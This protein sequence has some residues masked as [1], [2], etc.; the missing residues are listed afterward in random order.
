MSKPSEIL[1]LL[2]LLPND[3]IL[4]YYGIIMVRPRCTLCNVHIRRK[5]IGVRDGQLYR[6]GHNWI[7]S[8]GLRVRFSSDSLICL[9][10]HAKVFGCFAFYLRKKSTALIFLDAE[11]CR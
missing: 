6:D 9:K 5:R 4:I 2:K 3:H 8:E 10:C 11:K 7:K 1:V